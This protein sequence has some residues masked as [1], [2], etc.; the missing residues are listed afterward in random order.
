MGGCG[1]IN[2]ENSGDVS[3]DKI[4]EMIH[5]VE[6]YDIEVKPANIFRLEEVAKAFHAH[7]IRHKTLSDGDDSCEYW[8]VGDQS[9]EAERD[10]GSK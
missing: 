6:Q 5:F 9:L 8:Y 3:E 1:I 10:T 7:L 4:Q 2:A